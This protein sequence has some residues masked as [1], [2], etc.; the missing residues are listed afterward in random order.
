MYSLKEKQKY[1]EYLEFFHVVTRIS[2]LN[3]RLLSTGNWSDYSGNSEFT[4]VAFVG[5]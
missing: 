3:F 1:L 4:L 2:P 5:H